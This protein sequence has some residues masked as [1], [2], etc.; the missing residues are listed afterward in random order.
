MKRFSLLIVILT[1]VLGAAAQTVDAL[2]VKEFKLGNGLTVWLNEDHTQPK[3]YGA[4]VVRAGARDCPNT[5]I[6][7]YFEHILF[8]GTDRIGTVDYEAERPW[9]DSIADCYDRLAV[10]VD[11]DAR[12]Q[13]QRDINRLS[14]KAG[15][16][17][18]PNEFNNLISRYGGTGLNAY[19]SLDETVFFNTFSPQYIVQWAE[20]NSER[21]I[22]P[23]FRL[24][25]GELETVYEEKNMYS[26]NMVMPAVEAVQSRLFDGTPYAYPIIGSTENLKNPRLSEMQ[27]FFD[28]YYVAGNMGLILC[29]DLRGDTI[30]PLLERTFG[31]LRPGQAP[32]AAPVTPRPFGLDE[33][34]DLKV[35]IPLIKLQG[36]LYRA[37]KASDPDMVP[38]EMAMSL[39]SNDSGTGLLD[40]LEN[41]NKVM[42]VMAGA[43]D[44][45]RDGGLAGYGYVPKLPFGSK[46][47]A[48]R[49]C[50][51]QVERLKDGLFSDDALQ[52]LKTE[53]LRNAE[54]NL[55]DLNSR[56][57]M[58]VNAFSS[59][60]PW[61]E[62]IGK[63][64][65]VRAVTRDDIVRV[66]RKY[67]GDNR[68]QVTKRFGSY[69]KD[70]VSQPDYEPVT[71]KNAGQKSDYAKWLESVPVPDMAPRYLD[72]DRDAHATKL[73]PLAWLYTVDNPFNDIFRLQLIFHKGTVAD[74]K[75]EAVSSY[76]SQL[77]TDSLSRQE[78]GRALQRLGAKIDV[79]VDEDAFTV[80]LTGFD[81]S[82]AP[83]VSLLGHFLTAVK[84]DKDKFKDLLSE[85]KITDGSF[86]RENTSIAM[87]VLEKLTYGDRSE[88]INR[89]TAGELKAM[90][91]TDLISLFREVQE[92]ELSVIYS[93]TLDA[94]EVEREVRRGVDIARVTKPQT[95]PYRPLLGYDTPVVYI[96]DNPSARQTVIGTYQQLP[97]QSS[98][99]ARTRMRL[100]SNYLG[101]GMSSLM[102]QDIREFRSL[103]YYAMSSAEAPSLVRHADA[104]TACMTL[105]GTQADKAM[106]ALGVLDTLLSDMPMRESN[107]VAVKQSLLNEVNNNRPTFR[108]IGSEIAS[109]RARGYTDDPNRAMVSALAPLGA[110]DVMS[111]YNENVKP[112]ARVTFIVGDKRKLD[113]A[114]LEKY[115]RV[116]ELKNEEIYVTRR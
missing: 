67:L 88:Y 43:I 35:P 12:L 66:A 116:V 82:F 15:E 1:A 19:T 21:L 11:Q 63:A 27:A 24:F 76:V 79:S 95:D 34:M 4:V 87:A 18:I 46:K 16:Y 81:A 68:M 13:I 57:S 38:L 47:K 80:T 100:W 113:M 54:S 40:S 73:G 29:G 111:F 75:L 8:K 115:G 7:H 31:R 37:P 97:P 32:A 70:R 98:V 45:F 112:S 104:P 90:S 65:R 62:I 28:K 17:A 86:F 44:M 60:R 56:A 33:R 91:G 59:G 52:A 93:G 41:D 102:F 77:G 101:G 10:T 61:S 64:E 103:A 114:A 96:Y 39:L 9:L 51:E 22:N 72:F 50:Q 20:L 78:F 55:E 30:V 5:G 48:G 69:P 42:G 108:E 107:V 106:Q 74:P 58:M 99:D 105:L 14:L 94:S 110:S 89:L 84:A 23:V 49:L 3:A 36:Y 109:L 85:T 53:K 6:A 92:C 2:K 71:P 26:D 25:Q 83:S